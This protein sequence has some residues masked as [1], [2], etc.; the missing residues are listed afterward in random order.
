MTDVTLLLQRMGEGEHGAAEEL[1]AVVY[2]ELR[3]TAAQKMARESSGHTLQPTAL[4][5]EAWLRLGG[6]QQPVW[7]NRAHFFAASSESMRRILIDHARHRQTLRQGGGQQRINLDDLDLAAQV[8]DDQLLAVH[9]HLDQ[10]AAIDAKKAELVKLR[11]FTGLSIEEA[12]EVLGISVPTANRWWAF[13][14]AWLFQAM[15]P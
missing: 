13:A 5:H 1:L 9:D 12:A 10:F 14:R 2:N 15:K 3:R 8:D 4:V 6:D 7:Q 11:Y